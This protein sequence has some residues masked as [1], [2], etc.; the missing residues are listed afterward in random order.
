V[1]LTNQ[2]LS[3]VRVNTFRRNIGKEYWDGY[4]LSKM[5]GNVDIFN[6]RM[7]FLNDEALLESLKD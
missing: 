7:K 5:L 4:M 6:L 3:L 1:I 2:N